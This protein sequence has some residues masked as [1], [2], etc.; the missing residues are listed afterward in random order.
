MK[1][2]Q[3]TLLPENI[4]V[5]V[6]EGQ[7]LHTAI[8]EAGISIEGSCGGRGTCGKCKVKVIDGNISSAGDSGKKLSQQEIEAGWKL[9]CLIPVMDSITVWLPPKADEGDRKTHLG[10]GGNYSIDTSLQKQYLLLEKPTL[11]DQRSD[12]NRITAA[13]PIEKPQYTPQV[14]YKVP[15]VIRKAGFKVTITRLGDSLLDIEAGDTTGQ[16]YGA[17]FDI[18]TTTVVGSLINL[19]T[20]EVL[21]SHAEAN[22][23][24]SYGADVISRITYV[25]ENK[26]GL[27]ILHRKAIETINVIIDALT[28]K[29]QVSNEHIYSITTVGNT[30]MQHLLVSADPTF[31]A[32]SPYVPAFQ[33]SLKL[34]A[35]QLGI[36]VNKEAVLYTVPNVA[37]YVGA[38]TIGVIL[39]T[40][41]EKSE[42]IKLAIDIGTNGE[43]VLGNKDKLIACSTAAGPAFEGAQIRYGMRAAEGAIEKVRIQEGQVYLGVIGNN[44][45]IGICG[46]G[47]VDAVAEL[48]KTGI[49]EKSGRIAPPENLPEAPETL[50]SR[51]VKGQNGYDFV[52]YKSEDGLDTVLLTQKDVRELQLAKGAIYAGTKIL[53]KEAGIELKDIQKVLLAGAFGNYISVES[54]KVIGLLP[55]DLEV[56]QVGNAAGEGS[57][58]VLVSDFQKERAEDIAKTVHYL[59]LSSRPD[60]QEEFISSLGF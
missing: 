38:D 27:D 31:I 49:I 51:I 6:P 1:K 54:A 35:Y 24:R 30:C 8:T 4:L 50:T 41:L 55:K 47:L 36:N 58:M 59:E 32:G 16:L 3:V 48:V 56:E 29:A 5:A 33:S 43:L 7:S 14:I 13:L 11:Q 26:N 40:H 42:H 22:Q 9:A 34:N 2:Y 45:P 12:L 53:V 18:G 21:A 57:K 44:K 23:Q 52:L 17:A 10:G 20:G 46:S 39:A 60:F 15:K 28:A 19:N 37:G 25:T